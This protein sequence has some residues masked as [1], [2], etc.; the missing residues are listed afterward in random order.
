MLSGKIAANATPRR[1]RFDA[2]SSRWDVAT[3]MSLALRPVT[4]SSQLFLDDG[5]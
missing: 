3:D 2:L 1:I 4:S 5:R